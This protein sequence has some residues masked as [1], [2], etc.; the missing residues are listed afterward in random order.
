MSEP[1]DQTTTEEALGPEEVAAMQNPDVGDGT[2][3]T[4]PSEPVPET[5]ADKARRLMRR[6]R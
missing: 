5:L 1:Y 3:T 6:T 4:A 2:P